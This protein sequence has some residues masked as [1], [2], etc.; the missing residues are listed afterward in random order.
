MD[1]V[2]E[3]FLEDCNDQLQLLEDALITMQNI[4]DPSKLSDDKESINTIFRAM[5]TIKGSAG[6]FGFFDIVTFAHAA[7][8]LLDAAREDTIT[9]SPDMLDLFLV[10]KD[11]LEKLIEAETNEQKL[12]DENVNIGIELLKKLHS[13]MP[14]H[15]DSKE[16]ESKQEETVEKINEEKKK[17]R[18]EDILKWH[19]SI[20]FEKDFFTTGMSINSIFNFLNKMG[21]IT[22]NTPILY[23]IPSIE[24]LNPLT[25]YIGFELIL[26][27]DVSKDEIEDVFEFV[28][29]DVNLS[30]L[31]F[32]DSDNFE[33][34][35]TL[36]EIRQEEKLKQTLI[37]ANFYPA[38][39]FISTTQSEK[40]QKTVVTI[41]KDIEPEK[42]INIP[43]EQVQQKEPQE[44]IQKESVKESQSEVPTTAKKKPASMLRVDSS[45]IDLLI[46]YMSEIVIENSKILSLVEENANH[47]D[48]INNNNSDLEESAQKMRE[49]LEFV[50]DGIMDIRMIQVGDSF[51]KFR[52]IVNDT[53]KKIGKDVEFVISG[54]D[55]E[56]DKTVVERI[57]DPLVHMLRNSI[58]HGVE[59]PQDRI[60][61]GKPAK[62]R[63]DLRAYPD[64][65][66]IV[67]EIQDDGKGLDKERIL[68]KAIENGQ[69][70]VGANLSDSQI[71]KLIFEAGLS[72]AEK[73]SDISGRGVGM[74]V[75]RRNIED[76]RGT[77]DIE[78]EIDV[79]SK[80]AIR[81]PLTLAVID[82]FLVQVG[83]T[84]YIIP[85]D[86]IQECIE[87]TKKEQNSMKGNNFINL[88]G[89]ML[90][91]MDVRK[92]LQEQQS[93]SQ[94]ENIVIVHFGEKMVGLLVDE[95]L[96][97]HQTVIKPLGPV[98]ENI[99]GISGGSILGSG[100]IALIFDIARL[101]EKSI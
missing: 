52:R 79:G 92:L 23:N 49:L 46:N 44:T 54:G 2:L 101:I 1:E 13:F 76:L 51:N 3:I 75:V 6:M 69:V 88:R 62:G 47:G 95:L 39:V 90:P 97:E 31:L 98:F 77:I 40:N 93:N 73:V 7:E 5:H 21:T 64:S 83:E 91:I 27:A 38:Q 60:A 63:V 66:T 33:D 26:E 14:G 18:V 20:R 16:E 37:D 53:S 84:K 17:E 30:I 48:T 57:S 68:A 36:I 56:L 29:D 8:D 15:E 9:V 50:R 94:R 4:D 65:G 58:D 10:S 100:E 86:S 11:H 99:D 74:D 34:I 67:I 55:T 35:N 80:I 25:P 59:I 78:S 42:E 71:Y 96:G 85:L 45:K 87:L 43:Q 72:T 24:N 61:K 12:D 82:G 28:Y 32:E 81:L 22:T 41:P 70:Q 89:D 19:I